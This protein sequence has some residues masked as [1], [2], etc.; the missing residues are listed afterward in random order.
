MKGMFTMG[1]GSQGVF[2]NQVAIRQPFLGQQAPINLDQLRKDMSMAEDKLAAVNQWMANRPDY[3]AILGID[4]NRWNTFQAQAAG[5]ANDATSV[6]ARINTDDP[7]S[8]K[9]TTGERTSVYNWITAIDQ[10]YQLTMAHPQPKP[11]AGKI[12]SAQRAR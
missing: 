7:A 8:W 1:F 10:L 4:L 12:P 9:I 5:G 2:V 11:A 3:Q 6:E